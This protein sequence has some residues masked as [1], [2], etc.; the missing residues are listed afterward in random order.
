MVGDMARARQGHGDSPSLPSPFRHAHG[1]S[2]YPVGCRY[3]MV[4]CRRWPLR[5]CTST[6]HMPDYG[7]NDEGG[8]AQAESSG[9]SGDSE[10]G[11]GASGGRGGAELWGKVRKAFRNKNDMDCDCKWC[12]VLGSNRCTIYAREMIMGSERGGKR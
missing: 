9:E 10:G 1:L 2:M 6:R 3:G 8:A 12:R 4:R 7:D 11:G 5:R